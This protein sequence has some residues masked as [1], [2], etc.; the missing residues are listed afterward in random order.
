MFNIWEGTIK[1][2]LLLTM[3]MAISSPLL[4]KCLSLQWQKRYISDKNCTRCDFF[5]QQLIPG[6]RRVFFGFK[7]LI[8]TSIYSRKD[9]GFILNLAKKGSCYFSKKSR[10]TEVNHQICILYM[11]YRQTFSY[12]F[13]SNLSHQLHRMF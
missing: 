3:I 5:S 13:K 9:N 6:T 8:L 11:S 7:P 12:S 4:L 10:K 2:I 1:L